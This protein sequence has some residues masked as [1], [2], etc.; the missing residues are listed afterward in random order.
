MLIKNALVYTKDFIFENKDLLVKDGKIAKIGENIAA[1]DEVFDAQGAYLIP[2]FINIHVHGA[3][4]Y[5]VMETT[6]DELEEVSKFFMNDGVT[7]YLPTTVAAPYE[8]VEA[9]AKRFAEYMKSPREGAH[10]L[11]VNI[12]GP[13]LNVNFRG[14]HATQYLATPESF[15]IDGIQKAAEGQIKVITLAPEVEGAAAFVKA[16][17]EQFKISL[18]HGG[19]DYEKCVEAFEAGATQVTHLFNT[20]P[21]I[22]HR[23]RGLIHAA[24]EAGV[25]AELICDNVHVDKS[26]VLMAIKMFGTDKIC[27][28]TDGVHAT[29]RKDGRYSFAGAP[30]TVVNGVAKNDDG[31]LVGGTSTMLQCVQNLVT[32]GISLE[33]AVRMATANPA[34]A[35]GVSDVKG[36]IDVGMDADLVLLDKALNVKKVWKK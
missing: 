29:G 22:H 11:G 7:S 13:Y 34:D 36:R 35:I 12:E 4:G 21:P 10:V 32:W 26:V 19:D 33:D 23:N 20:M 2:G 15:S 25:Y 30:F 14:A 16:Y 1:D 28:I 17:K 8:E 27:V 5:D 3:I 31:N 24:F 6:P 18:G 9:A